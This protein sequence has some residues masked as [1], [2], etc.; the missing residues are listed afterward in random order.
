MVKF[1]FVF[2]CLITND[3]MLS[4]KCAVNEII[5]KDSVWLRN[6]L[7]PPKKIDN[8]TTFNGKC[9]FTYK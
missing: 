6:L 3:K 9:V 1:I 4:I 7:V 2:Q 8:I 5:S